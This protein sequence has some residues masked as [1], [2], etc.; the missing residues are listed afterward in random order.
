MRRVRMYI[1]LCLALSLMLG[2]AY[3][4]GQAKPTIMHDKIGLA[5]RVLDGNGQPIRSPNG[6]NVQIS[7]FGKTPWPEH[8]WANIRGAPDQRGWLKTNAV[9]PVDSIFINNMVQMAAGKGE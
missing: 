4:L 6:I 2:L 8:L 9:F 1:A 3:R 7:R 5:L